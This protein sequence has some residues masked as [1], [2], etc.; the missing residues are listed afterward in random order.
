[1]SALLHPLRPPLSRLRCRSQLRRR[2]R[3]PQ[4]LH[5]AGAGVAAADGVCTLRQLL[6]HARCSR[7]CDCVS[8]G[9]CVH[10]RCTATAAVCQHGRLL[11]GMK[12]QRARSDGR[13]VADVV[14]CGSACACVQR[15][16]AGACAVV[17]PLRHCSPWLTPSRCLPTR[18]AAW[19]DAHSAGGGRRRPPG[20]MLPW[21][22][23]CWWCAGALRQWRCRKGVLGVQR[24]RA[25]V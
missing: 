17:H 21:R 19:S 1:M 24:Q 5:M 20:Q 11:P 7:P 18:T 2:Q 25:C 12:P 15:A 4:G 16:A 23:R 8:P 13:G 22:L 14:P 6:V 3:V 9:G 10:V